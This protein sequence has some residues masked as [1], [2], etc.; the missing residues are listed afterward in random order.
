MKTTD[1][2]LPRRMS[3]SALVIFFVKALSHFS[4]Y[5]FLIGIIK[6]I[7]QGENYS[8]LKLMVMFLMVAGISLLLA[9]AVALAGYYSKKF[10]VEN[11]N[12]VFVHHFI[13]REVTSIPLHKIQ[14][15]RTKRGV[16]YRLLDMTGIS[17]D[18]LASKE[19][20][21][22]L[23]LDDA[24]W[25]ALLGQVKMQEQM[26]QESAETPAE[27]EATD[28][29]VRTLGFDNM[30]LIKGAF[31]QNHLRG[32]AVLGGLLVAF[33]GKVSSLGD[34]VLVYAMDYAEAYANSFS[35]SLSL[36]LIAFA[37][38]YLLVML[39][40]IGKVCLRYFNLKVQISKQQLFFEGGLLTRLSSRF[41]Y[42]KVCTVYV[43]QNILEKWLGCNTLVLKQAFNATGKDNENNVKIYGSNVSCYFLDWWLG[44]DYASSAE[45]LLAQSGRGVAGYA[46]KNELLLV[47]AASA[48]L[49][50][51]EWYEWL[52]VSVVLLLV[53][54]AKGV[55]AIRHS[56]L[57]LKEDYLVV[58]TGTFAH[59]YNYMKY[60]D[61]EMV[62]LVRTPF[63]PYFHRVH[64][65][66]CTN[67]TWFVVR[68]LKEQEA[69]DIYEFLLG[70]CSEKKHDSTHSDVGIN[71]IA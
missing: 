33:Y 31:C 3:K 23:I 4:G 40:W 48:A 34:K 27:K 11:G 63:T 39:L 19:V 24:D 22:E 5:V 26:P 28:S 59:I 54:L 30:N 65:T 58:N 16:L 42:D 43:K 20:E 56:N 17:F 69:S 61:I 45:V 47:L 9:A 64:L 51:L 13:R 8:M 52:V 37:M 38:L 60:G 53:L 1:F 67:G 36:V 70:K 41:S 49:C 7:N 50:Y 18:T 25:E 62:R 15:M 46:V 10:Y 55:C 57:T 12:L 14:S 71:D 35:Y 21:I 66:L 6:I 29:E 68:S 32:M 44:K 2:S